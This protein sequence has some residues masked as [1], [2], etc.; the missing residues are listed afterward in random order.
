MV[1]KEARRT[2][3]IAGR[4]TSTVPARAVTVIGS[5]LISAG[6][7]RMLSASSC[8]SGI[9]RIA[10]PQATATPSAT[11]PTT[12]QTPGR[13]RPFGKTSSRTM[14]E[15]GR[16]TPNR[17]RNHTAKVIPGHSRSSVTPARM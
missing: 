11:R 9:T 10:S 3:R 6:S 5:T 4:T 17:S 12:P 15:I 14:I 8:S 7:I 1:T 2:P 16:N 13:K